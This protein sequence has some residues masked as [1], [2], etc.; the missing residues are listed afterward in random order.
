MAVTGQTPNEKLVPQPPM[1]ETRPSA[2]ESVERKPEMPKAPEQAEQEVED[3]STPATE[4]EAAPPPAPVE[5]SAP[6]TVASTKDEFEQEIDQ[7]L[8]EDMTD[9]FLKMNPR[10]QEAFK[11]RGEETATKVRGLL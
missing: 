10:Q 9:L 1:P 5:P 2:P 4:P 11:K 8:S 7:I 6:V 3:E